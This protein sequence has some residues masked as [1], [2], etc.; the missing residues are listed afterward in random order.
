MVP[1]PDLSE[2]QIDSL[3]AHIRHLEREYRRSRPGAKP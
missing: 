1:N 3:I 2:A